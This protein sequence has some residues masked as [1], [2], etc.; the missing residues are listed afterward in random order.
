MNRLITPDE[1]AR[2]VIESIDRASGGDPKVA[3]VLLDYFSAL[4]FEGPNSGG[5]PNT[6]KA[7]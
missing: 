1:M 6:G 2:S 7:K 3:R 5:S 4:M